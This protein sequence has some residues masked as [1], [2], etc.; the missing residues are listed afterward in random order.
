MAK[1]FRKLGKISKYGYLSAEIPPQKGTDR[2]PP[3]KLWVTLPKYRDGANS[4]KDMKGY[5]ADLTMSGCPVVR[6]E[7]T[8][9]VF[10]LG[11][12]A[13]IT[14]SKRCGINRR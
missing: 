12:D 5:V 7:K 11:W 9:K 13:I 3:D 10:I 14:L 4:R 2:Y 6:S 1:T 8:G